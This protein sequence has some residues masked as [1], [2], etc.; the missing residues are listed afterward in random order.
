MG[1]R[2]ERGPDGAE[3][4]VEPCEER[5]RRCLELGERESA[6]YYGGLGLGTIDGCLIAEELA[7]GCPAV[8][9]SMMSPSSGSTGGIRTP[10]MMW[11]MPL[12]ARTS[13]VVTFTVPLSVLISITNELR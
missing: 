12:D 6:G 13:V 7:Y 11:M 5:A 2:R 4:G 1:A 3:S 10:S 9:T 8:A